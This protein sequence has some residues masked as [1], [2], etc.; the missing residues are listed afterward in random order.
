[1]STPERFQEHFSHPGG[2]ILAYS[3]S[4]F[5]PR[6]LHMICGSLAV[7][8]LFVA[9]LGQFRKTSDQELAKHALQTGM[10]S[11]LILTSINIL[12]GL[13]YLLSLPSE[14]MTLFLGGNG[15]A[16]AALIMALLLVTGALYG[17]WK[18]RLWLT[19]SH[20]VLLV[21]VMTI[22]RS[23]L[24]T[25]YLKDVFT[26]D[27]LQVVPQYSPMVFFFVTLAAGIVCLVWLIKKTSE[28]FSEG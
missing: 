7:G 5:W 6:F 11:F 18:K 26:L 1:M 17:A 24:R 14:L 22:M 16:T 27:Q 2:S 8:G 15:G 10:N 25:E 21:I 19:L 13:W 9:L 20:G 4:G 3:Q 12:I 23:W 28:A